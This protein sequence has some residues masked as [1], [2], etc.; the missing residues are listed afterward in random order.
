MLSYDKPFQVPNTLQSV[1]CWWQRVPWLVWEIIPYIYLDN[2]ANLSI[3]RHS[4]AA[5]SC[6]YVE[7][8]IQNHLSPKLEHHQHC[9]CRFFGFPAPSLLILSELFTDSSFRALLGTSPKGSDASWASH[10]KLHP[11]LLTVLVHLGATSPQGD[12][13]LTIKAF[14]FCLY[15][16]DYNTRQ[17]V[18]VVYDRKA[19][20]K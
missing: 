11:H 12:G 19:Q 16:K 6:E 13:T 10:S 7:H 17:K 18:T 15:V 1:P 8:I 4:S 5:L 20:L 3:S 9:Y 14:S 2:K